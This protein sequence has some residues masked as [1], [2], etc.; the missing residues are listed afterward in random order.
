[1]PT[2]A[3]QEE[4]GKNADGC[5]SDELQHVLLFIKKT[6]Y[7]LQTAL[8]LGYYMHPSMA[9]LQ[10]RTVTTWRYRTYLHLMKTPPIYAF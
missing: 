6:A 3:I 2:D 10:A 9:V 8:R 1:M 4:E 7:S 5:L